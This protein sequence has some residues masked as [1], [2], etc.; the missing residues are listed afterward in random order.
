M[1]EALTLVVITS[2]IWLYVLARVVFAAYFKS[3]RDYLKEFFHGKP[4][5]KE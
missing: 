3:K 5:Q 2:P 1:G 4:D